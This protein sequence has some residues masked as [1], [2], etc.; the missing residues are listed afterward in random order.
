VGLNY[1]QQV[2][3]RAQAWANQSLTEKRSPDG[4]RELAAVWSA[5]QGQPAGGCRQCQ[6]SDYNAVITTYLREFSRLQNPELMSES[7]YQLAPQFAD[8]SLVDEGLNGVFTADNLTDEVAEYFIGKGRTDLFVKKGEA[9]QVAATDASKS[10]AADTKAADALKAEKK[11]HTETKKELSEV[12]KQLAEANKQ[13]AD[14]AEAAEKAK[15]TATP[16][17]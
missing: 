4:L 17:A 5:I 7:T 8:V 14:I 3:D 16:A 1:S 2:A 13:L 6:Y 9:A 15:A 11:A 12:Q 10:T